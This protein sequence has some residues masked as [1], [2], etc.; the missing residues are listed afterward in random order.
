M[1]KLSENEQKIIVSWNVVVDALLAD[2]QQQRDGVLR[3]FGVDVHL[4]KLYLRAMLRG[5]KALAM[6][7]S[8]PDD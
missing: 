2:I 7:V 1:T 3:A 4:S 6:F 8:P 5:V